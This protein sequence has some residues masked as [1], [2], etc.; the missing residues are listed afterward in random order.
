MYGELDKNAYSE[1]KSASKEFNAASNLGTITRTQVTRD[2]AGFMPN[3]P[4]AVM[5]LP[6]CMLSI[7]RQRVSSRVLNVLYNP[8]AANNET[9][10]DMR[11][12]GLKVAKAVYATEAKG[13][14]VNLWVVCGSYQEESVVVM[15][16]IK[17]ADQA[18]NLLKAAYPLTNPSFIRRQFLKF[19]EVNP[20]L[21]DKNFKENHGFV[22]PS[23]MLENDVKKNF[24]YDIF[25]SYY[26]VRDLIQEEINEKFSK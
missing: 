17:T 25:L 1:M 2:I 8:S 5:N 3:V 12:A 18:N 13:I 4:A 15:I 20:E 24:D 22:T 14:R 21:T 26:E 16:K 10:E 9:I 7:K 11:A 6:K 19:I 23:I